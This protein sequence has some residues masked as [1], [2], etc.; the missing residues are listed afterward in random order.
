MR[1]WSWAGDL[2]TAAGIAAVLFIGLLSAP[3]SAFN[4]IED[5][6][7]VNPPEESLMPAGLVPEDAVDSIVFIIPEDISQSWL[8]LEAME[9][10]HVRQAA[11][12]DRLSLAVPDHDVLPTDLPGQPV[13]EFS[14]PVLLRDHSPSSFPDVKTQ[15]IAPLVQLT[16]RP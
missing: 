6:A 12:G 5:A 9:N 10:E 7:L 3:L 11:L 1:R 13:Y 2:L 8:T 16:K 15:T 14:Y 4:P